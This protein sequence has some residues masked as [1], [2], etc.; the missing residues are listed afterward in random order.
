M[1]SRKQRIVMYFLV[2]RIFSMIFYDK[3]G[4]GYEIGMDNDD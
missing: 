3:D 1:E 2:S 4:N